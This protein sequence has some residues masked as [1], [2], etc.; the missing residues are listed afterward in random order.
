MCGH[1]TFLSPTLFFS[2]IISLN[3]FYQVILPSDVE[4]EV[5]LSYS[6]GGGYSSTSTSTSIALSISVTPSSTS[7]SPPLVLAMDAVSSVTEVGDRVGD[8][9]CPQ[10]QNLPNTIFNNIDIRPSRVYRLG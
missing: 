1:N 4:T 10:A 8:K 3:I 7:R 5:F 9:V 6:S 2:L